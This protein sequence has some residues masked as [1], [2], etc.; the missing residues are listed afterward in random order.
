[1][2]SEEEKQK[3]LSSKI[4]ENEKEQFIEY[5]TLIASTEKREVDINAWT[6]DELKKIV[7]AFKKKQNNLNNYD[8]SQSEEDNTCRDKW[9]HR[10]SCTRG[11]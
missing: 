9:R 2:E 1:M 6:K 10:K 8:S 7:K 11:I 5:F 4:D 3:Y